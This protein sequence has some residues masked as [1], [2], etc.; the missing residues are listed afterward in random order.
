MVSINVIY[1]K[2]KILIFIILV[3][4]HI[5]IMEPFCNLIYF[6]LGKKAVLSIK[7]LFF[8]PFFINIKQCLS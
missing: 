7:R 2:H 3:F 4:S 5:F 8:I 6:S 1:Q